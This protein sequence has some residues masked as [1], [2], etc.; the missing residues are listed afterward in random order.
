[1]NNAQSLGGGYAVKPMLAFADLAIQ[2]GVWNS[3]YQ[4]FAGPVGHLALTPPPAG[5]YFPMAIFQPPDPSVDYGHSPTS[6]ARR[7]KPAPS[8]QQF[9]GCSIQY[10]GHGPLRL[11]RSP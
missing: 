4:G 9:R 8:L 3:E 5:T 7:G 11:A 1:V 2:K 10:P 6:G